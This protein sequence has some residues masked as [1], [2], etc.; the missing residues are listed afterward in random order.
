MPGYF[1]LHWI[2]TYILGSPLMALLLLVIIYLIIDRRFIGLL[3]DFSRGFKLRRR[4]AR[5][6]E[7]LRL[8]PSNAG[9]LAEL[10]ELLL[11]RGETG[12]ALSLLEKAHERSEDSARLLL[13]LGSCYR[14]LGRTDEAVSVLERAVNLN[15]K[16]GYG[17]PHFHLLAIA[18]GHSKPDPVRVEQLTDGVLRYGSAEFLYRSGREFQ[19]AGNRAQAR[20]MYQEALDSYRACPRALRKLQRRWATLSR[21][22]M[23]FG[24]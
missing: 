1:F 19:I 20:T 12:R 17:E 9:A 14:K 13:L 22:A 10:G 6:E 5:L 15:G 18:L 8:N 11:G 4:A 3:P 7:D 2:L 16:I 23:A 21:L 24:T